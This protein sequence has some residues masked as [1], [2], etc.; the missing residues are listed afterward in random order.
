MRN[1]YC[2]LIAFLVMLNLTAA[3]APA[4]PAAPTVY[5]LLAG[6]RIDTNIGAGVKGNIELLQS[7]KDDIRQAGFRV[8]EHDV[9]DPDFSCASIRK[10]VDDIH[11]A[12][13]DVVIFYYSGHGY[14]TQGSATTFPEFD[15]RIAPADPF[16]GLVSAVQILHQK[17]TPPRLIIGVADACNTLLVAP[18]FGTRGGIS[19][20]ELVPGLKH[21]LGDFRGTILAAA[22]K[23]NDY[24]YYQTVGAAKGFFTDAFISIIRN[25]ALHKRS[26][27]SWDAIQAKAVKPIVVGPDYDPQEPTMELDLMPAPQ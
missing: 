22:A 18:P 9:L 15:C 3:S 8:D 13:D 14:R 5:F 6:N 12:A 7:F 27:A 11:P 16:L 20:Q 1:T 24:A 2:G 4:Q 23:P 26:D 19:A 10:L 21:L 25:E 17:T